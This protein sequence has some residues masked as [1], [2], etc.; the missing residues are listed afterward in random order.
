MKISL[1][2]K[3]PL[4]IAADLLIIFVSPSWKEEVS[5]LGADTLDLISD[6][7][8]IE[9][10][11]GREKQHLFVDLQQKPVKRLLLYGVGEGKITNLY[12]LQ[13]IVG[14]AISLANKSRRRKVVLV[15]M[16]DWLKQNTAEAVSQAVAEA[17]ILA[18]YTFDKY[19]G[20]KHHQ[21]KL[22]IEEIVLTASAPRL[23]AFEKGIA[24]AKLYSGATLFA[25]DLVNEPARITTPSYLAKIAQGFVKPRQIKVRIY[26]K[27]EIAK[28]GMNAFLGVSQGSDEPPKLIKLTYK[29]ARSTNKKI[30]LV[31]KGITFDTGGLSLKS[32]SSMETMKL[33]MAGAATILA[34][35]SKIAELKPNIEVVAFIAACE[36][37]PSGKALKPGDILKAYNGKTV[38]VL[39]TDAEGR[40]TLADTLSFAQISEKPQALI[41]LATLTGA[42]MV[43]LGQDIAGLFSN[44]QKLTAKVKEAACRSGELVWE[45]PLLADYKEQIKSEVADLKNSSKT[46]FGGA[47]TAALF[48]EEFVGKIPWVHLDIAGPAFA[49]KNTPLCTH[50]GT[51][52]GVRLLLHLL[53]NY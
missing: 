14:E 32:S 29:P 40:L 53:S 41:D 35:F 49:E 10:F 17:A 23:S 21:E 7:A 27:E 22:A 38:E 16:T 42:M 28:L 52:F 26:E 25:R 6:V 5:S 39:N 45:M 36:N 8:L 31:G 24:L 46:R 43:A 2:A 9:N 48:L 12:E 19:K 13:K 44:N 4:K 50:G 30:V 51:G 15:V 34:V 33:D 1:T 3:N 11:I 18:T 20:E 37:M 47:I